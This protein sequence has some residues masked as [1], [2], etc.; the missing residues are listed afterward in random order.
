MHLGFGL[1]IYHAIDDHSL[2]PEVEGFLGE[3]DANPVTG[4]LM[5]SEN[6]DIALHA[7]FQFLQWKKNKA[8][9]PRAR[10]DVLQIYQERSRNGDKR[11]EDLATTVKD[12]GK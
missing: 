12:S 8:S 1:P 10:K 3:A 2:F 4:E 7:L 5:R 6:T 9:K 11:V